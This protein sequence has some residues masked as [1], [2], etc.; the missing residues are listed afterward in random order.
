M[1]RKQWRAQQ[2]QQKAQVLVHLRGKSYSIPEAGALAALE[3]NRKNLQ[4]AVDIYGLILAKVP[5][6][7][8]VHNNR[9][10]ILHEMK[11]YE[12]ALASY[13]NAIALKPDYVKAH[14]NRGITLREML[15]YQD[16]L[17]SC[18]KAITIQPGYA[19]AH[20]NRGATLQALQ[21]YDDALA[22]YD[23]AL[24]LEP[25]NAKAHNNRGAT[26]VSKG[27]MEEAERTFLKAHALMPDFPDP[28]A[29]LALVRKY[30]SVDDPAV[31]GIRDL[32]DKPGISLDSM[33]HLY[34]SLGKIYDDC[35]LYDQAFESYRL[36]NQIRNANVSYNPDAVTRMSH[37]ITDVFSKE[38]LGQQFAFASESQSPLLIVGMPRSGTTLMATILSNHRSIATAGE[39]PTIPN[40]TSR[41]AEL[42]GKGIPYPQAALHI[43]FAIATG[44]INEYEKRLRRDVGPD[45]PHVIDKHPLNFRSLGFISMLFP[46]AR[47]I[48]CTRHPWDTILSNYFQRFAM[49]YNYSFDLRNICHFYGEY[50]RLMDHWRKTL[51]AKM[52]EVSYEEMVINTESMTRK[53][54]DVLGLEWDERCLAPHTN[55]CAVGTA[56]QWQVRQPIYNRSLE[57]WRHYEK[58]LALVKELCPLSGSG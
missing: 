56:S 34:F 27:N 32:L 3:H 6:Y 40:L 48:H 53:T 58:H 35:D 55:P 51:P 38:F 13:D 54:L 10:V 50:I 8:E 1:K 20:N 9:G 25:G 23:K 14:N 19:E 11:R 5:G 41:L 30:Q 15:R 7:A 43:D 2:F 46:K 28:L 37:S 39:L 49:D 29:N 31:K 16:A 22:S 57:R 42:T 17:A 36:A 21:R 24:A 44:L 18:D 26:L 33:E 45:I 47:V 52:L 4:A 12:D